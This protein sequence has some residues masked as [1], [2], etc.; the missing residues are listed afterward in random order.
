GGEDSGQIG[1]E[2][3]ASGDFGGFDAGGFGDF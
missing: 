1:G 3:D 2:A